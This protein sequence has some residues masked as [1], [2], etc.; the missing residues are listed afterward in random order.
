M[1][2]EI[3]YHTRRFFRTIWGFVESEWRPL[4]LTLLL[5]Y[6]AVPVNHIKYDSHQVYV[7]HGVNKKCA[8]MYWYVCNK[9]Y[10]MF[11]F[12]GVLWYIWLMYFHWAF[13][14]NLILFPTL[15]IPDLSWG[16]RLSDNCGGHDCHQ[17]FDVLDSLMWWRPAIHT[18]H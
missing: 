1:I 5:G 13:V 8:W 6:T 4:P 16:R 15:L 12:L 10:G 17:S 3:V 14:Y 7:W 18:N 11:R 2:F 9:T